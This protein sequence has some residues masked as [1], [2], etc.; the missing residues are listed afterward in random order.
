MQ[1]LIDRLLNIFHVVETQNHGS[2]MLVF[3][4]G[5]LFGGIIQYS[6][7]DKFEKIAGFAMLKDTIVPKM[8]FLAIG[9]ASIGLYFMIKAGYA[10]YHVKPIILG[11]LI[12]G[13]TLFG[14]SMAILGKCPGTGPIS[15]AEGRIDVL[16]GAIGGLL[17]GLVF[18]IK[19]DFFKKIIGENIGKT[20]IT[21]LFK[22]HEDLTILI[23]G[24]ALIAIS[25]LIPKLEEFDEAD[26]AKLE[27][28]IKD[29]QNAKLA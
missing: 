4:I 22:G 14:I 7:V 10:H 12:V 19:Y 13:G 17:G 24:I 1:D 28:D 5:I 25:I 27:E 18:D 3:M 20:T 23:F 21:D 9:I 29:I 11:G 6:R 26:L 16:V 8:L 15:I 2:L